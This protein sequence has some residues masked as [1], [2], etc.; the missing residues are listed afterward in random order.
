LR[1]MAW[2]G[3]YLVVGFAGGAIPKLPLNLVLLKGCDVQGVFWGEFVRRDPAANSANM[4]ELLAW[5]AAGKL[6]AHVHGVYP[7][8]QTPE[9]LGVIARREAKGKV[10]VRP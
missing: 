3:R 1:S 7:L 4:A 9:A 8:E 10:L 5:A 2:E 6:Q